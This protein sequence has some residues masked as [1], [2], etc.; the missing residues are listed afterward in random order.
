MALFSERNNLVPDE[1]I[2]QLESA[3]KKLRTSVFNAL[4]V[5]MSLDDPY[6]WDETLARQFWILLWRNPLDRFP[7]NPYEFGQILKQSLLSCEWF[8]VYDAIEFVINAQKDNYHRQWDDFQ[9]VINSIL[10]KERSGYRI[11]NG[12]TA[13]I[14]N[15][16]ELQSLEDSLKLPERF[17]GAGL[18]I[19]NAISQFS[20]RPNPDYRNTVKEAISAVESVAKVITGNDHA[21]LGEALGIL[22]NKEIAHP[23]LLE[24]WK[25][26][27]GF[28][29]NED[30]IR[31]GSMSGEIK[32]DY[33]LAKYMLVS[34]SAFSN[35]L[36]E[37]DSKSTKGC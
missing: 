31:H 23:A 26:I 32:V 8:G 4:Y 18:H 5:H 6:S 7:N 30:G 22:Q 1:Q 10:E 37:L 16:E 15:D 21:S 3:N 13:P 19:Q 11:I 27:Y 36:I 28:T 29:C 9:N 34:C 25:K 35:Y 20:K 17:S 12:L 24:G 14:A 2:I 33:S